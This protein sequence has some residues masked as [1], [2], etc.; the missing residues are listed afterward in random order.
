MLRWGILGTSFISHTV[1]DAISASDGSQIVAVA[2]RD[3]GRLAEFADQHAIARRYSTVDAMVDD[4]DIDVVYVGLPNNV[5]HEA[6]IK[7]AAKGKA[8]LSEKSLTTTMA[9]AQALAAAVRQSR[10][11]F[12]EGLMYLSHPIIAE[13]GGIIRSGRLGTVRSIAGLYA[14]DIWKL[15]NPLG[16]GTLYN[17]GCYPAS[18]LQYVVQTAFGP[19]AFADRSI[20]GHGNIS[21]HDGNICDAS[22]SIRFG[23]GTLATLQSTDSYGMSFD[24]VVRGDLG[25]VRFRTNPWLPTAGDN[26][27]EIEDYGRPSEQI[28]VPSDFDA[29]GQQVRLVE[30]CI[31]EELKEAPRPSPRLT[32]S[33]EIM[34]LLTEWENAVRAPAT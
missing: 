13:L 32:D 25:S 33:I 12:L 9:E 27:L 28:R 8:V 18:L 24:F 7:A 1:A 17:L 4:P 3:P 15:V 19:Q 11:F 5:H 6:V 21:S 2:G 22:L 26:I 31:A 20:S 14:A 23:N 16:K 34:E 10:I 30:R 29:F